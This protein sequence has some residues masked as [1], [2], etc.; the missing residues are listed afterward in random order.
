[1]VGR[2]K[3]LVWVLK[4]ER[5]GFYSRAEAVGAVGIAA[6]DGDVAV[7]SVPRW[8]G[9][10]GVHGWSSRWRRSLTGAEREVARPGAGCGAGVGCGLRCGRALKA[11]EGRWS[12]SSTG[13]RPGGDVVVMGHG[14]YGGAVVWGRRHTEGE[15]EL[16]R[17]GG[18]MARGG[19]GGMTTGR[20]IR[21]GRR[22]RRTGKKPFSAEENENAK[23]G[24]RKWKGDFQKG[25][26]S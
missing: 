1:M 17:R 19:A 21:G 12:G 6:P 18:E 11:R 8:G 9:R 24:K 15:R 4:A 10:H 3:G 13:A 23:R 20:D 2:G 14:W 16:V 22:G 26:E 5:G 25:K 7:G